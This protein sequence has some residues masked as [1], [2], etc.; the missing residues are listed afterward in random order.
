LEEGVSPAFPMLESADV[1]QQRLSNFRYLPLALMVIAAVAAVFWWGNRLQFPYQGVWQD[2]YTIVRFSK[3]GSCDI[4][5]PNGQNKVK[6]SCSYSLNGNGAI[7]SVRI[8]DFGSGRGP[9]DTTFTWRVTPDNGG[10]ILHIKTI[11]T[12]VRHQETGKLIYEHWDRTQSGSRTVH[13][14]R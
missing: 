12:S 8:S 1:M 7:V 14:I 2:Q 4:V 9:T 5:G 13:K 11:G 3:N 10:Q 6:R